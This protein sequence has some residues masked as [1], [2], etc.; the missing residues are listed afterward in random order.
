VASSAKPFGSRFWALSSEFEDS[1]D[2]IWED[3]GATEGIDGVRGV[4]SPLGVGILTED[5]ITEPNKPIPKPN[6]PKPKYLF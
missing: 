6:R 1:D 2:E 3:D 5:R 4:G